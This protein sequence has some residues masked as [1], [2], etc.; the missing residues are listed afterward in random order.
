MATEAA[1]AAKA[2]VKVSSYEKGSGIKV[3]EHERA[4]PGG[5]G[6]Q[7][8]EAPASSSTDDKVTNGEAPTAE[9]RAK[10]T[11]TVEEYLAMTLREQQEEMIRR[12]VAE[13]PQKQELVERDA[14]LNAPLPTEEPDGMWRFVTDFN[15][16]AK[17]LHKEND[18]KVKSIRAQILQKK[19]HMDEPETW[20]LDSL[21]CHLHLAGMST[22]ADK[23][24]QMQYKF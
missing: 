1:A 18:P 9:K 15:A 16:L 20:G 5:G 21:I 12:T 17:E 24:M 23:V 13:D 2:A 22:L 11:M 14:A 6:G 3:S 4:L 19:Y 8:R 7:K 10:P